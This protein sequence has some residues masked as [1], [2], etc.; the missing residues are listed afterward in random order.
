MPNMKHQDISAPR[1][2]PHGDPAEYDETM[3]WLDGLQPEAIAADHTEDLARVG[4]AALTLAQDE[5]TLE[6]AIR[7]AREHGRSWTEIALRLGVSRQ[8]ARQR[9]GARVEF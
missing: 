8:A 7:A 5:Q 9:F 2:E 1:A 4:E 6:N 3:E